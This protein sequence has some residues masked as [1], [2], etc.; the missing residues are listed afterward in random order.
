MLHI[1]PATESDLPLIQQMAYATW[2]ATYGSILSQT[3][4]EYMLEL[5]YNLAILKQQVEQKC[6]VF[7]LVFSDEEALGFVSYQLNYQ[8][9]TTTKIHKIYVLPQAQ[10]KGA[11]KALVD[12]V[13][14]IARQN[15]NNALILNVNQ[16]NKAVSFYK[17]SGFQQ[18]GNE[19]LDIGNGFVMD[20]F[21]MQKNL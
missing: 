1:R 9:S 7:L 14:T 11:G 2:P 3:Q 8:D 15:N 17:R 6:Q 18:V 12:A 21:I 13:E 4:I 16:F 5:M 19:V 20:D 10:G